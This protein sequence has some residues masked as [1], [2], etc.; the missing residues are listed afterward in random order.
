MA[1]LVV[2]NGSFEEYKIDGVIEIALASQNKYPMLLQW[3]QQ[4]GYSIDSFSLPPP[5]DRFRRLKGKIGKK[6]KQSSPIYPSI[7]II[8]NDDFSSLSKP[9]TMFYELEESLF[10][11]EDL[12]GA[13][14]VSYQFG[15]REKVVESYGINTHITRTERHA[16]TSKTGIMINKYYK[17]NKITMH[18]LTR[19][20]DAFDRC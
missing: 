2:E 15:G 14:I 17:K 8:K 1:K 9:Q 6:S 5:T 20:V 4:H 12:L 16:L 3:S 13:I 19:I 7:L 18:S 10:K 11:C